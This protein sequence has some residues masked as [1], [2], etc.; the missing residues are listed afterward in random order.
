[1]TKAG[2][3]APLRLYLRIVFGMTWGVGLVM[4]LLP[5]DRT[6]ARTA[7]WFLAVGA[8]S[9]AGFVTARSLGKAAFADF[10]ARVFGGRRVVAAILGIVALILALHAAGAWFA[11]LAFHWPKGQAGVAALASGVLAATLS[12]P[13]PLEEFGWRGF[14]APLLQQRFSPLPA[15]V[16]VG[17]IWGL[18][19]LPTLVI[20]S[21]PQHDPSLPLALSVLRFLAQTVGL[22]VLMVAALNWTRGAVWPAMAAHWAANQGAGGHLWAFDQTVWTLAVCSGAVI[23]VALQHAGLAPKGAPVRQKLREPAA[24]A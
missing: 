10:R 11:G 21:F 9:I 23:V 1:M 20:P 15:S 12:D 14:L 4:L 2:I 18:W 22:S 5:A 16:L 17:L 24:E 7:L 19:H 8:P 3:A 6:A 13:G